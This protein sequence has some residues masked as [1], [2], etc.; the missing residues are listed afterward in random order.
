MDVL[1]VCGALALS[2]AL[3]I[4]LEFG[5]PGAPEAFF[6]PAVLYAI[7]SITW[8]F[9]FSRSNVYGPRRSPQI[10]GELWNILIGHTI[11][12]FIFFGILYTH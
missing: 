3:R 10:W 2:S 11:A 9:A 6:N 1:M 4:R 8:L 5:K 12:S 7:A